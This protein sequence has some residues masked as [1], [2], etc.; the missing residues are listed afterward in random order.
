M[1]DCQ[2]FWRKSFLG[3]DRHPPSDLKKG[4][5][6]K[7]SAPGK[8]FS[9]FFDNL[10]TAA[11]LQ[12]AE[13]DMYGGVKFTRKTTSAWRKRQPRGSHCRH[14]FPEGQ[15]PDP[16]GDLLPPSPCR[17]ICSNRCPVCMGFLGDL[18]GEAERRSERLPGSRGRLIWQ[19]T[20]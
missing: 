10:T 6:G 13:R 19:A 9:L 3:K 8:F 2:F 11:S 18:N 20:R 15:Y 5:G 7:E 14:R 17:R 4:K 16:T 12:G 1:S